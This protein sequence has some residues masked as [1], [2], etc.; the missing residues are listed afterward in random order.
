M[1][2]YRDYCAPDFC[3]AFWDCTPLYLHAGRLISIDRVF[4]E[5]KNPGDLIQWA[6]NSPSGLFVTSGEQQI[7]SNFARIMAW[8]NGNSQFF[9]EA[10][11]K[12]AAGADGWLIAY[13]HM[14]NAVVVT[15]EVLAP[16]VQQRVPIPNVCRQFN[17]SYLNTFDMLRQLGV[18]F[19]LRH[20]Q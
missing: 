11:A 20:T 17:V 13:A 9:D 7:A 1:Q 16:D 10:K 18:H 15:Q 4:A 2:A 8:V 19:D 14:H 3:P 5:I 6:Q 12:F